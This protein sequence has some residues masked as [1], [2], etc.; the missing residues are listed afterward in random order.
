MICKTFYGGDDVIFLYYHPK[1]PMYCSSLSGCL[2][3]VSWFLVE[4]ESHKKAPKQSQ[5]IHIYFK[6]E[7]VH[8]ECSK[9]AP[10]SVGF[11]Y[12]RVIAI[13]KASRYV[14]LLGYTKLL[15]MVSGIRSINPIP[16][17]TL[18]FS[19][20]TTTSTYFL[21]S[22]EL[23]LCLYYAFFCFLPQE[24]KAWNELSKLLWNLLVSDPH[25]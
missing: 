8:I 17:K 9:I 23:F 25:H 3:N 19:L 5:N 2:I 22:K 24:L 20:S 4:W 18:P 11:C 6:V 14:L 21:P 10:F 7:I 15:F 1:E 16:Y 13:S 12:W